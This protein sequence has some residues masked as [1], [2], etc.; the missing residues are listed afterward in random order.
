MMPTGQLNQHCIPTCGMWRAAGATTCGS[1]A[2][3]MTHTL[4]MCGQQTSGWL[5]KPGS[6]NPHAHMLG[7]SGVRGT[8]CSAATGRLDQHDSKSRRTAWKPSSGPC[9]GPSR[10]GGAEVSWEAGWTESGLGSGRP[11]VP[12]PVGAETMPLT[13]WGRDTQ[14]VCRGLG[15]PDRSP[16]CLALLSD[17]GEQPNPQVPGHL[18]AASCR[19]RQRRVAGRLLLP[20]HTVPHLRLLSCR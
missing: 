1:E 5:G 6:K 19:C 13:A 9:H 20:Q 2:P 18:V 17:T 7:I 14:S 11:R 12:G 16:F 8:L 3:A 10:E 4:R 15:H